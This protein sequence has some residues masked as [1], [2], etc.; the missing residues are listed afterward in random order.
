MYKHLTFE[1]SDVCNAYCPW[2][3]TGLANMRKDKTRSSAR[4]TYDEFVRAIEH[5]EAEELLAKDATVALHV[6][7][8]PFLN[9]DW[10]KIVTYLSKK[11]HPTHMASN[12]SVVL[13]VDEDDHET[14]LSGLAQLG[15]SMP[16]F[17]Q[18]SYT[19]IHGFQFEKIKQN[20]TESVRNMRAHPTFK[21]PIKINFHVYQFNEAEIRPAHYFARSLGVDFAPYYASINNLEQYMA[22][23]DGTIPVDELREASKTL[24]LHHVDEYLA[25]EPKDFECPQFQFLTLNAKTEV[26]T[27]CG[28]SAKNPNYS[29]GNLYDLTADEVREKKRQQEYC[30]ACHQTGLAYLVHKMNT[31]DENLYKV[32]R[33]SVTEE[34]VFRGKK[35]VKRLLGRR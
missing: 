32:T 5:L 29:I 9:T 23:L 31:P 19:K 10:K 12:A 21:A 20:I 26:L 35:A 6:W 4:I 14:D 15:F 30:T 3:V 25:E 28:V 24:N 16:G 18:K 22:Y 13:S 34:L 11:G 1:I 27:C 2:C 33:D 17:S 8:E 7:G